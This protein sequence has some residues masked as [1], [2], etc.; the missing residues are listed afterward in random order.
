MRQNPGTPAKA[1]PKNLNQAQ[2]KSCA[3]R[4]KSQP[5]PSKHVT[6][7]SRRPRRAHPA[8]VLAVGRMPTAKPARCRRYELPCEP[9]GPRQFATCPTKLLERSGNASLDAWLACLPDEAD[10]K[11]GHGNGYCLLATEWRRN[12]AQ[13]AALGKRSELEQS[14]TC[15]ELS[16][17]GGA[18]PLSG[19]V[20]AGDCL[21]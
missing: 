11:S 9:N 10:A 13:C 19:T 2:I 12:L 15:P 18:K 4:M 1:P 20:P 7:P 16:R 5:H 8:P 21:P 17:R 6:P 14:P 3:D